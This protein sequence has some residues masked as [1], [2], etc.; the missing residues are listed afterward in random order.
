MKMIKVKKI[1]GGVKLLRNILKLLNLQKSVAEDEK[2]EKKG[3]ES[4]HDGISFE[5]IKLTDKSLDED[6]KGEKKGEG[7]NYVG[8]Y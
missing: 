1:G 3:E 8:I 5:I 4:N 7:S 2:G 6:E